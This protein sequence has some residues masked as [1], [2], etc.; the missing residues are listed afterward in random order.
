[1][2]ESFVPSRH[3]LS[4]TLPDKAEAGN[5]LDAWLQKPSGRAG[6]DSLSNDNTVFRRASLDC[7][8][9][10]NSGDDLIALKQSLH[11]HHSPSAGSPPS[12]VNAD[13][14]ARCNGLTIDSLLLDWQQLADHDQAILS[15]VVDL[16]PGELIE[17]AQLQECLFRAI[18]PTAEQWQMSATSLHILQQVCRRYKDDEVADW[19]AQECFAETLRWERMKL[20]A[21]ALCSD[22]DTDCRRLAREVKAFL[23][24]PLP[25]HRLPL[26]P[27]DTDAGEGLEF[28][29]IMTQKDKEKMGVF[30][31]EALEVTRDTLVYLMQSLKAE[32]AAGERQEF[33][34]SMSTYRGASRPLSTASPSANTP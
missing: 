7:I 13:D 2:A 34:E 11:S 32:M 21:P 27:V 22:H 3:A 29:K 30:E 23:K 14:Y 6:R 31:Q 24:E 8:M 15:T 5:G 17:T 1:M 9:E 12:I 16:E 18:I 25:D 28:P 20:D 33:A 26:H 4:L 19:V 10:L